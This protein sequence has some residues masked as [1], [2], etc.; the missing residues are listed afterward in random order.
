MSH[1]KKHILGADKQETVLHEFKQHT[2]GLVIIWSVVFVVLVGMLAALY[3]FSANQATLG[4]DGNILASGLT[5]VILSII[6][7]VLGMVAHYVFSKNELIITDQ[8]VIEITQTSLFNRKISQLNLAKIQDV[9]VKQ[10]GVA[11]HML[12]YGTVSIETAGEQTSYSFNLC[13]N[14]SVCAKHI[15]EA[16]EDYM[17][18]NHHNSS[19][20]KSQPIATAA[21]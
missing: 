15:I 3:L 8:N 12:G 18:K 5:T 4:L 9:S 19:D 21:F 11:S 13:P 14:A 20:N 7:L 10:T 17:R 2:F 1:A 16:H 6:V